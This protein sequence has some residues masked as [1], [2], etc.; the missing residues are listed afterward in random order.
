[1]KNGIIKD[2]KLKNLELR[3]KISQQQSLFENIKSDRLVYSKQL[4][5]AQ[6]EL[7]DLS[8]K[9]KHAQ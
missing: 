1:M 4:K 6:Q 7:A 2:F 8:E 9:F 3:T 5:E